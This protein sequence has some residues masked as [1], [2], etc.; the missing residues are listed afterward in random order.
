MASSQRILVR[1]PTDV[2]AWLLTQ[3]E[4]NASHQTAEIVRSVR[5]RMERENKRNPRAVDCKTG[6]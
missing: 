2:R 1:L 5:E 6:D 4:R 3:C